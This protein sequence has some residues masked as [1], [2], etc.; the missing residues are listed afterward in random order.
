MV[1][2]PED[3]VG[4]P[5]DY[6]LATLPSGEVRRRFLELLGPFE[7]PSVPLDLA[8]TESVELAGGVM[9][10]RVE[11]SVAPG[12]RVPAYHL[13]LRDLPADAPGVL[14]IHGH[15]GDEIFPVGK[16]YHC[17][18]DPR[19]PQQYSYR[20][21][22]TG[23][24]VLAPDALCFG[25]RR[26]AWGHARNFFDEI[27]KHAELVSLGSSLA[28]KS[29]WDNSRALE[30]LEALGATRLGA[31]GW[32]GGSTQAYI[33]ASAN[34]GL[35]AAACNFSFATLRH[36]FYR[37]RVC[38]CLYHFIPRMMAAGIDWDQ[39]VATVAPRKLFFGWG[40]L[41]EGT[42][43]PMYR[44]FVDAVRRRCR[45]ESLPDSLTLHEEPDVGHVV[46]EAM[47]TAALKFLAAALKAPSRAKR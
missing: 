47:L 27:N 31:I 29:V 21:A 42:P 46:T 16:A 18:P 43:E 28:W 8:V 30:A 9:R 34:T 2:I 1:N 14:S 13:F 38:H 20:A 37:Y 44:A 15:G 4:K 23:L 36:Q 7:Q 12:E 33:L 5:S 45:A 11:Y 17:H 25:E 41:D 24:R 39:V 32:S 10:E 19:D 26:I 22:L 6:P 35:Q 40:A 3:F